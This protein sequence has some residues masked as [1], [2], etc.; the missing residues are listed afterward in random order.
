MAMFNVRGIGVAVMVRISTSERRDFKRYNVLL[1][2]TIIETGIDVPNANTI[3][4]DRADKFG[5]AQLHQ[6]RGRVGRSHHQAYAYLLTPHPKSVSA[7]AQK[8]LEAISMAEDLGAGFTL[9]THDL[10]IR[11]AGE[12]LGE[13]QSGQIQGIGFTLYM[14]MLEEAIQSIKEG[15]TPN[16]DKPLNHGAEINLRIPA[17]IPDDYL[18]DVHNRLIMYKRISGAKNETELKELQIEMIDRFGMLPEQTKNL[19]RQTQIKLTADALGI[20]KLDAGSASGKLEFDTEPKVDPFTLVT[21]VQRYPTK[22]KLEGAS[23]LKFIFPMEDSEAR[24]N[25][26]EGVLESLATPPKN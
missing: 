20:I 9:A 8:R 6:L 11:G 10:E 2:T 16:L 21:L 7:D 22:F 24:F 23:H 5:L 13:E 4:I 17:L 26:V 18:P 12:L 25:A 1:S 3:I 19:F 14:E 15:K